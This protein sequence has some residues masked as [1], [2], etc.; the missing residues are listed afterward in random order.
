MKIEATFFDWDNTLVTQGDLIQVCQKATLEH[1]FTGKELVEKMEIF[2]ENN[3]SPKKIFSEIFNNQKDEAKE[4][5]Y[6]KYNE[7][8]LSLLQPIKEMEEAL[9]YSKKQDIPIAIISSKTH[10]ILMKEVKHLGYEKYFNCI[11]GSGLISFDK[12]DSRL[13]EY[14]RG[15]MQISHSNN[16]IFVGDSIV[17]ISSAYNSECLP[18]IINPR[19]KFLKHTIFHFDDSKSFVN[20]YKGRSR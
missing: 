2:I 1:I 11:A 14:A 7:M 16:Q 10:N 5:F 15:Q 17:D 13:V 6:T 12:P 18:V 8:H 4:F 19:E 20:W 9:L 3:Q